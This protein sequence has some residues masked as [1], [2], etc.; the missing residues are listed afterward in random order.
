MFKR[1]NRHHITLLRHAAAETRFAYGAP[2][3][4]RKDRSPKI[5]RRLLPSLGDHNYAGWQCL[6][7]GARNRTIRQLAAVG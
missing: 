2:Q 7:R 5:A 4:G 1:Q 3:R 6:Q